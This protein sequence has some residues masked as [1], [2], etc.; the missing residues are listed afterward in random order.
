MAQFFSGLMIGGIVG[1]LAA[2]MI[3]GGTSHEK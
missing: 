2:A 3:A 1:F